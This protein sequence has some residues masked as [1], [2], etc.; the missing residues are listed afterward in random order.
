MYSPSK[1]FEALKTN[2]GIYEVSLRE[3]WLIQNNPSYWESVVF[4]SVVVNDKHT[5]RDRLNR[6][7][8]INA[9]RE[10]RY[11]E[12][13]VISCTLRGSE[14]KL[15]QESVKALRRYNSGLEEEL[16]DG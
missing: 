4:E 2:P 3:G 11:Q 7:V 15:H 14:V 13:F 6:K 1:L 5:P 9:S 10:L 12:P 8:V 16:Q